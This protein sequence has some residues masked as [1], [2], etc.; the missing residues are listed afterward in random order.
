MKGKGFSNAHP[1]FYCQLMEHDVTTRECV[2]LCLSTA[3]TRLSRSRTATAANVSSLKF[4]HQGQGHYLTSLFLPTHS[5]RSVLQPQ[6][7]STTFLCM[8]SHEWS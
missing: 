5:A 3:G 6:S 4:Q 1:T 7:K 8:S 2:D